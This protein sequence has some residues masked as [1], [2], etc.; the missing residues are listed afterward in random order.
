MSLFNSLLDVG[1]S[2]IPGGG[3]AADIV[4]GV[5]SNSGTTG[6]RFTME[7]A[8]EGRGMNHEALMETT[9]DEHKKGLEHKALV[10][11][12]K[13]ET[14]YWEQNAKGATSA[15]ELIGDLKDNNWSS[16]STF[17]NDMTS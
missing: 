7:N 2:F 9:A 1:A 13:L 4:R 15:A 14:E 12:N 11:D 8:A 10:A 17:A 5:T 16:L 3:V 6:D